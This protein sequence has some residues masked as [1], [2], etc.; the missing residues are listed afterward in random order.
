MGAQE[1]LTGLVHG[2]EVQA[3]IATLPRPGLQERVLL[4]MDKIGIFPAAGAKAGVEIIGHR[5]DFMYH[6]GT[7]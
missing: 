4:P 1:V 3:G 2:V 6:H 5:N 7:G